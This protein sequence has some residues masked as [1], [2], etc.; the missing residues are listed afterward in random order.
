MTHWVAEPA[1]S[2][3]LADEVLVAA[4]DPERGTPIRLNPTAVAIWDE[5]QEAS[6]VAEIAERLEVPVD[7]ATV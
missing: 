7:R 4:I 3:R 6:T 5:V 1:L 2:R